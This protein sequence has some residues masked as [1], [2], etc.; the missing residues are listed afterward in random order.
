MSGRHVFGGIAISNLRRL[1]VWMLVW[2]P[3]AW[4]FIKTLN[5]EVW[6]GCFF[7]FYPSRERGNILPTFGKKGNITM[8]PDKSLNNSKTGIVH[9]ACFLVGIP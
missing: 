8:Y 4:V 9:R 1:A 6:F 5:D 7:L 2:G 3:V